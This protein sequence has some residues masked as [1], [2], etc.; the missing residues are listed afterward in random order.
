M[1]RVTAPCALA[2]LVTI[3]CLGGSNPDTVR[4]QQQSFL[5]KERVETGTVRVILGQ[6]A[7]ES[8]LTYFPGTDYSSSSSSSV[9]KAFRVE[10]WVTAMESSRASEVC[11]SYRNIDIQNTTGI[12]AEKI[13][14]PGSDWKV[15]QTYLMKVKADGARE[16]NHETLATSDDEIRRHVQRDV[17]IDLLPGREVKVGESWK[18]AKEKLGLIALSTPADKIDTAD[19]SVKLESA[20]STKAGDL[21]ANLSISG[22][23]KISTVVD[24]GFGDKPET[25]LSSDVKFSGTAQFSVTRGQMIHYEWKGDGSARGRMGG[26]DVSAVATFAEVNDYGYASVFDNKVENGKEGPDSATDIQTFKYG[27]VDAAHILIARNDGKVA[28]I[29]VFDPVSRKVIKTLLA[30]PGTNSLNTLALSPDRKRVAF[31]S[32]LNAGI[33]IADMDVFVLELES[34]KINQVSPGWADNN[35]IAQP[36]DSGK[37]T[38]LSGRIVW[39]DNDEQVR[40][41]RSDGFTGSARLDHTTCHVVVGVDGKF[42][43]TGVPANTPVLLH[44]RGRLPNYSNGK[45]R[46][47]FEQWAGLTTVSMVIEESGKDLGDVRITPGSVDHRHD[48]PCW[49]GDSLWV[50]L[51]GWT[52]SYKVG[53]P[54]HTWEQVDFGKELELLCGGFSVSRDGKLVAQVRDSSGGNGALHMY[55]ISGKHL[56]S[57]ALP[58]ATVSYTAEGAWT[59]DG[60]WACTAGIDNTM[61]KGYFGAPGLVIAQPGQKVGGLYRSWPQLYGHA[62]VS[63]ALDESSSVGYMVTHKYDPDKNMTYG[64]A[65]AWDSTTDAM[66]RLT[67]L[68]DVIC[69]ASYGR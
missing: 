25:E 8:T 43:L 1:R 18:V 7:M 11:R 49:Q 50:N 27:A 33:S 42:T 29:Q 54:K 46:G 2:M 21:V 56:W 60:N 35:G 34:G 4:A 5:L 58:G 26:T 9:E 55:E 13:T 39:Y 59:A 53:Y 32:N 47:A 38:T 52:R 15:N 22:T 44:I 6:R 17:D 20:V 64:D 48:R 19:V 65:W 63:L 12:G 67:S 37:T 30:M 36:L 68:G 61:G 41:D 31:S 57:V 3:A 62:M 66:I 69:V 23:L 16:I 28:R 14:V 45:T 40:R 24:S 51:S 10:E